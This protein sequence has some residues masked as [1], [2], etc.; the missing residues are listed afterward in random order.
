MKPRH[1]FSLF[2]ILI[3]FATNADTQS[4]NSGYWNNQRQSIPP[5]GDSSNLNNRQQENSNRPES[6]SSPQNSAYFKQRLEREQLYEAYNLLHTLAQV[7]VVMF[8][9]CII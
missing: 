2:N 4:S 7:D 1:S 8:I 9:P 3:F 5:K 6:V